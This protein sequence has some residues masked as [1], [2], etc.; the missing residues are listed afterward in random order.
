MHC[1]ICFPLKLEPLSRL[2]SPLSFWMGLTNAQHSISSGLQNVLLD[3]LEK[4]LPKPTVQN[5]AFVLKHRNLGNTMQT[6]LWNHKLTQN[7]T[8]GAPS[9]QPPEPPKA[10]PSLSTKNRT[11]LELNTPKQNHLVQKG[12]N[13][14]RMT[15]TQETMLGNCLQSSAFSRV[16]FSRLLVQLPLFLMWQGSIFPGNSRNTWL[17][18]QHLQLHQ[19][20]CYRGNSFHISPRIFPRAFISAPTHN[21]ASALFFGATFSTSWLCQE[22]PNNCL[23][24]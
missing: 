5:E 6:N 21:S 4:N 11:N 13:R 1:D 24:S 15:D 8:D 20:A 12:K 10:N 7:G 9:T 16:P 2:W 17:L 3:V 19:I 18:K 22:A 14:S 23:S